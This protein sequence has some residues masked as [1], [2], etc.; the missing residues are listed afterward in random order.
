MTYTIMKNNC[1]GPDEPASI[2]TLGRYFSVLAKPVIFNW[3]VN[4][5]INI[6]EQLNGGIR[7]LDLRVAT[8]N[9]DNKIY[10]LHGLYGAEIKQ[11]LKDISDWL[12]IHP[13]EVVIMDFQ[14]FYDFTDDY[15]HILIN[16]IMYL[17][18]GK[19]CP[20]YSKL[21]HI[22]LQWLNLEKYQIF[23]IYRNI[24]ARNYND[25][26]PSSLWPT[27]WPNTVDTIKLIHIL[28]NGL[29]HRM[30]DIGFISQCLLTPDSSYIIQHICGNLKEDLF[31]KCQLVTLPWIKE[32]S[33]GTGAM[34]IVIADFV[35]FDNFL[36]SRTVIQR[37]LTL[38][39]L[40]S[41][42]TSILYVK[43]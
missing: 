9:N 41:C 1:I 33:P 10:F 4:Q 42:T 23:I 11:P 32:N 25:L 6:K 29:K 22:S 38:L 26:W 39:G 37:N 35:S 36:F 28:N 15:H 30:H 5:N 34:N 40:M 7:Y 21:E 43:L 12:S 14:H 27:P 17:F 3:S 19:I 2:R 31:L 18:Q 16:H 13:N 8:K 20:A 24:V